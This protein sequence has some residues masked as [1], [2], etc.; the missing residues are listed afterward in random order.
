MHRYGAVFLFSPQEIATLRANSGPL[1][2]AYGQH[3]KHGGKRKNITQHGRGPN[4]RAV[5]FHRKMTISLI[6]MSSDTCFAS[7]LMY[8]PL[9][10]NASGSQNSMFTSDG[11]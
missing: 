2:L 8:F 9:A 1:D 6:M 4:S 7:I 11:A 10:F 5:K 3:V